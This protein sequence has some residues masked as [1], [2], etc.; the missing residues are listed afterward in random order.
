MNRLSR[1]V[2]EHGEHGIARVVHDAAPVACNGDGYLVEVFGEPAM[3]GVLVLA[4]QARVARHIGV[5][6]GGELAGQAIFH[7][8]V[9]FFELGRSGG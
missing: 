4:C 3:G 2:F 8:V 6:D 7:S 1:P 5:Q 9:P